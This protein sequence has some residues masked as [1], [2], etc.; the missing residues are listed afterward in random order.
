MSII[1][2]ISTIQSFM[3]IILDVAP[4]VDTRIYVQVV[5]AN[6]GGVVAMVEGLSGFVPFSQISIALKN[7]P[8]VGDPRRLR[9]ACSVR[10]CSTQY[11]RGS[12]LVGVAAFMWA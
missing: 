6:K 2:D 10:R 5:G 11:L 8:K 12:W 1:Y 4:M 7:C 9:Q 3:I